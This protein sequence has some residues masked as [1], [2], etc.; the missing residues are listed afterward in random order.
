[1]RQ[2]LNFN[3]DFNA[4]VFMDIGDLHAHLPHVNQNNEY[5]FVV[6]G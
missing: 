2:V 5:Q 4:V 6:L 3:C 1:M